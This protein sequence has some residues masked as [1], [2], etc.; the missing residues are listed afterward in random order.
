MTKHYKPLWQ[1]WAELGAEGK[2]RGQRYIHLNVNNP[3]IA[4]K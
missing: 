2:Q 3:Y 1:L 4:I